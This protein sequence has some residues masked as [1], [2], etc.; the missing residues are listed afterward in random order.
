MRKGKQERQEKERREA[1][2]EEK[3]WDRMIVSP[4]WG[5]LL[6]TREI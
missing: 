6:A 4:C 2:E 1:E 5:Q 3:E